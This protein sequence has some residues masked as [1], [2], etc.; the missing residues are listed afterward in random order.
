MLDYI[1]YCR[2][3][4]RNTLAGMTDEQAATPLP[5]A[6]RYSGQPHLWIIT[7]LVVHTTEHASQIRQFI[8]SFGITPAGIEATSRD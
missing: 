5:Q 7:G 1:D 6:H 8:T 2:H 4:A 3:Q